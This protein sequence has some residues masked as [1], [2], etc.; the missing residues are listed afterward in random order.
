MPER[1]TRRTVGVQGRSPWRAPFQLNIC[2]LMAYAF[3]T[4]PIAAPEGPTAE[5]NAFLRSHRILK[6]DRQWVDQGTSSL[7]SL[8]VE[9]LDGS[10]NSARADGQAGMRGKIDYK[11]VL[12]AED[13]ALFAKLRDARKEIAQA[14]AVPVYTIF[15]NE[16]LAQM[17]SSRATTR[18]ALAK[19]EGIGAARIE[20]YGDRMLAILQTGVNVSAEPH[21]KDGKPI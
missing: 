6:V 4:I 18:A 13:F 5:L 20:K 9:Y 2:A 14:E 21:E 8:C 10:G 15:T 17:V 3:F 11:Q 12:P 1:H 7:W 16:Q 19:I